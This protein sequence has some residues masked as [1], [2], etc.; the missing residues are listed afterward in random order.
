MESIKASLISQHEVQSN[1]LMIWRNLDEEH[2]H[3]PTTL[4][5]FCMHQ[6]EAVHEK[7]PLNRSQ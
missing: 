4:C 3:E 1:S 6:M 7:D 2:V 5:I